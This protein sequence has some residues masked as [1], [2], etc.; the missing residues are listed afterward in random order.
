MEANLTAPSP[1]PK[2]CL[3]PEVTLDSQLLGNAGPPYVFRSRQFPN[4]VDPSKMELWS[5]DSY[6]ENL[7][8]RGKE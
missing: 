4:N 2:K 8:K 5:I 6:T 3:W 1:P 7:T